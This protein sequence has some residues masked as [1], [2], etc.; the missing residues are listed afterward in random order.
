MTTHFVRFN[1][2]TSLWDIYASFYGDTN[3]LFS[4]E[5]QEDAMLIAEDL[6]A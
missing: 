4:V 1:D 2:A 6:G 3:Y 5:S